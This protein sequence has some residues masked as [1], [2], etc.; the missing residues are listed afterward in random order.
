MA[1]R[2]QKGRSHQTS[3]GKRP[4]ADKAVESTDLAAAAASRPTRKWLGPLTVGAVAV[5][6]L[7][8]YLGTLAP[9]VS[10]G[11]SGELISAAYVGGVAHPPG[12]PLFTMMGWVATHLWPGSPA[13][14]MNFLSAL[15]QAA[16][17][18]L[19]GLLTAR[20]IDPDWPNGD[21]RAPTIAGAAAATTLAVS[22]AFWAYALVAEVFAL[23]N[24]FTVS[25]LLL[26]I[27]WYRDRTKVWALWTL[28]LIS[29]LAAA[30]QQTIVL[31]GPALAVLLIAGV[32]E[33]ATM[34]RSRR[35][36]ERKKRVVKPAHFV[37]GVAFIVLGLAAYLWLPIAAA[38]DPVMNF[39]D[40]ETPDRFMNVVSRGPYGSLSLIPG[41]ER[42]PVGENLTLY[43]GYLWRAFTPLGL[44][45]AAVGISTLWRSHRIESIALLAAF[46]FTGPTFVM[47]AA[48]PLDDPITRG[49]VERFYI[50][51]SLMVAIAIGIGVFAVMARV[52]QR[53]VVTERT[54]LLISGMVI[55]VLV[56]ALAA[57]RRDSVDQSDNRVAEQYGRD[58]LRDLEPDALLLTRGDHNY[59]S[60]AYAQ[61]VDGYRTDVVV[62]D[63]ELL[64]LPS[65][66]VELRQRHPHIVFPF[67]IYQR[68]SFVD[69]VAA[70]LGQRAVYVAGPLADEAEDLVME[71]RAGL[72]RRLTFDTSADE[73]GI[74]LDNPSL[75]TSLLFPDAGY[76]DTT[77][78]ALIGRNYG[79]AAHALG[80]AFHE[81]EPTPND[82]LV[83]EMYLLSVT[84]DGP[85]EVYKN[86]GLFYWERGGDPAEIID[87]WETYLAL[88]PDD[89]QTGDIRRAIAQLETG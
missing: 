20:L 85:A 81:P 7:L 60:M 66:L 19:V 89:P 31:L 84:L 83:E 5:G 10:T 3:R 75:V 86:L 46:L 9:T 33:D 36:R 28:G 59:T 67:E 64:T 49:I 57:V 78:E 58:L 47:F 87:L 37:G 62:L 79:N 70:N 29:G 11:D 16:T 43:L 45:L 35:R 44:L 27:E 55:V 25:L 53:K 61:Y 41:Q 63:F 51:S 40:P 39:G 82:S 26:A 30:H 80:F 23:N 8:V 71:L 56:G 52:I 42:G 2:G 21:H 72:V 76:P 69:L 73:Y 32:R 48:A 18:G 65:Y 1:K 88:D 17:V 15:F 74:L 24:L 13:V 6:A 14:I 54:V 77:W 22:T 4:A 12:Y 38:T 68:A 50:L 34:A